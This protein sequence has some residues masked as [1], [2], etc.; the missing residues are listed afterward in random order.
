MRIVYAFALAVALSCGIAAAAA[1]H[2]VID[3]AANK[4]IQK[5]QQASCEQLWQQKNQPK[6]P[7]AQRVVQ[8]L[9]GDPAM[10]TAFINEVAA[11]I[12]NK[13]FDC[14]MIP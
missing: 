6:S 5:Y 8:L 2:P 10:R 4:V 1:Q 7:E 9:Q 11:P 14:G 13:L 12:A 3:A